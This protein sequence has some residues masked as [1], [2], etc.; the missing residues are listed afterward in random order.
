MWGSDIWAETKQWEKGLPNAWINTVTRAIK[1]A[2]SLGI[3]PR[4]R[5]RS[6]CLEFPNC[7]HL[8]LGTIFI[9]RMRKGKVLTPK[10]DAA[11]H[12]ESLFGLLNT[13]FYNS[14]TIAEFFTR[15]VLPYMTAAFTI[16][17]PLLDPG[18]SITHF[19]SIPR[20]PYQTTPSASI[21]AMLG[22]RS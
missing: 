2:A 13:Y 14:T 6:R 8:T 18:P 22:S 3:E 1:R 20:R 9:P 15:P 5:V 17:A 12:R 10:F 16:S 4:L 7:N 11:R 21:Q 19:H